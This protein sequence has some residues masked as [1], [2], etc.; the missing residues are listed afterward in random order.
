LEVL[1]I[2]LLALIIDLVFGDPP[3]AFH[4][5]AYMGRVIAI[6]ERAGFKGGRV[7]QFVYGIVMVFIAMALFFYT[8]IFS[9]GLAAW[10]KQCSLHNSVSRF[11]QDVFYGNRLA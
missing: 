10:S 8:G 11:T 4:P 7:Y 2:F 3:N 6:F 9:A 1:F 5:V